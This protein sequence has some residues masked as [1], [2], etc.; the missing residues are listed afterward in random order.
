M[1]SD[2][3][4]AKGSLTRRE[5]IRAASATTLSQAPEPMHYR[6]IAAIVLR[7]LGL[8][9]EVTPKALN[10]TLHEDPRRRFHLVSPGTWTLNQ[11]KRNP[12]FAIR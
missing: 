4:A 2:I 10:N 11:E 3:E 6:E 1:L 8:E 9:G 5:R 7:S 12:R